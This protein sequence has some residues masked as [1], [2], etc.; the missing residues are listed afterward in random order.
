MRSTRTS[1]WLIGVLTGLYVL[2]LV[3]PQRAVLGREGYE[4]LRTGSPALFALLD[5][6]GFLEI[7]TSPVTIAVLALF[8]VHLGIVFFERSRKILTRCAVHM[9][10]TVSIP[11]ETV[12]LAGTSAEAMVRRVRERLRGFILLADAGRFVAVRNRY[13]PVGL[14]LF[15]LSFFI[16]LLGGLT[17]FY[18]RSQGTVMLTE[19]QDFQGEQW[20]DLVPSRLGQ[21]P[22]VT[23]TVQDIRPGFDAGQIVDMDVDVAVYT[24]AQVGQFTPYTV[25][26]NEPAVLGETSVYIRD[27]GVAPLL[28]IMDLNNEMYEYAFLNLEVLDGRNDAF[29]IPYT[30]YRLDFEFYPD[31]AVEDGLEFSRSEKMNNPLFHVY[32]S[33]RGRLVWNGTI[34]KGQTVEAGPL[35]IYME[36]LRFWG[37]FLVVR[38][39]GRAFM[40]IGMTLALIGLVWR[41]FF[42]RVE[43]KG[44]VEGGELRLAVSGGTTRLAAEETLGA[45]AEGLRA[46]PAEEGVNDA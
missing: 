43:I 24:S 12:P 44:V 45:L 4:T 28:K 6:I 35:R 17:L 19:G 13:A 8:F 20:L 22:R 36:D 42:N 11:A 14:V 9:P 40:V 1:A 15:H 46:Y 3:I 31:Y 16:L 38:E 2:G 5:G 18:T 10:E 30:G 21:V 27:V 26:V 41:F 7:Y 37:K 32:L 33:E 25:G 29:E 34:Q 23:M 39:Q